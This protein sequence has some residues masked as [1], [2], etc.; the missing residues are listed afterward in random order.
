MILHAES[1]LFVFIHLDTQLEPMIYFMAQLVASFG[2]FISWTL[3]YMAYRCTR[4]FSTTLRLFYLPR[5]EPMKECKSVNLLF[6]LSMFLLLKSQT[7]AI[8]YVFSYIPNHLNL[9]VG[10]PMLF[11]FSPFN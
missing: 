4:F 10:S 11:N 7:S 8:K 6:F 2:T 1:D 3:P 9:E 5:Y